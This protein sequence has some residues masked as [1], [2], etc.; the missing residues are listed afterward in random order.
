[1]LTLSEFSCRPIPRTSSAAWWEMVSQS[2]WTGHSHGTSPSSE[3]KEKQDAA[4][5]RL[6]SHYAA[7]RT[8]TL[9]PGVQETLSAL[10]NAGLAC[11]VFTNGTKPSGLMFWK[12]WALPLWSGPFA[13]QTIDFYE[14][15]TLR[16]FCML[17][18]HL[19]SGL[20]PRSW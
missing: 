1:M 7:T 5:E 10:H 13:G 8:T 12:A 18:K 16:A 6:F 4:L 15:L 11:G 20:K 2:S 17:W 14:S 19:A 9:Y 3:E